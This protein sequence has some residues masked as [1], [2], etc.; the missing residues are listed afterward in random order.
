MGRW[1]G[2]RALGKAR[3][4]SRARGSRAGVPV[5]APKGGVSYRPW[6]VRQRRPSHRWR[7][8]VLRRRRR[9]RP[10]APRG[11]F[12]VAPPTSG[13]GT[14]RERTGG[15]VRERWRCLGDRAR[16]PGGGLCESFGPRSAQS[17]LRGRVGWAGA[18]GR[19]SHLWD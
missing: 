10:A 19:R 9:L 13:G 3:K 15:R 14:S 18:A 1:S 17:G 8:G 16:R 6:P 5:W 11:H 7:D 2:S 4:G 12:R